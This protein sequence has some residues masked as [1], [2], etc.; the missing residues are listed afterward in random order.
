VSEKKVA[1]QSCC[2]AFEMNSC[3][4]ARTTIDVHSTT[5]LFVTSEEQEQEMLSTSFNVTVVEDTTSR[6]KKRMMIINNNR[7]SI[8]KSKKYTQEE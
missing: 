3:E 6:N 8:N 2:I 1:Y 7:N 5:P 4:F